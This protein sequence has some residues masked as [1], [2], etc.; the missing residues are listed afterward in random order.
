MEKKAEELLNLYKNLS[1]KMMDDLIDLGVSIFK[2]DTDSDAK[3]EY[4]DPMLPENQH[5][6]SKYH[7]KNIK[8]S[9]G[10]VQEE[11][12]EEINGKM[13][14]FITTYIF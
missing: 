3:I 2:T 8:N 5:L 11:H 10:F 7:Q 1:D 9:V 13:H 6:L 4:V 14:K 12:F